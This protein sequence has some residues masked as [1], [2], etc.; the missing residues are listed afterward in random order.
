MTNPQ[1]INDDANGEGLQAFRAMGC[2]RTR[3]LVTRW[4]VVGKISRR[5]FPCDVLTNGFVAEDPDWGEAENGKWSE[6]EWRQLEFAWHGSE[7]RQRKKHPEA[8]VPGGAKDRATSGGDWT[9]TIP[10]VR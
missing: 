6:L 9:L 4:P 2:T 8:A 10:S 1:T 3:T 5:A 7:I